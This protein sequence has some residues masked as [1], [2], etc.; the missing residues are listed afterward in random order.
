MPIA[1]IVQ[2]QEI[3]TFFPE[4][5]DCNVCKASSTNGWPRLVIF[6]VCLVLFTG[7]PHPI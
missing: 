2:Y 3:G 5:L 1:D 6:Q 7:A 4:T